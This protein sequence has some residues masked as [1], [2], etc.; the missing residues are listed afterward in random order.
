MLAS[1][2]SDGFNRT[3]FYIVKRN[4]SD[5]WIGAFK[6]VIRFFIE[7]EIIGSDT[8]VNTGF[9]KIALNH[10]EETLALVFG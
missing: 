8:S 9:V 6:N 1:V 3:V 2:S 4:T 5:D 10:F 7:V